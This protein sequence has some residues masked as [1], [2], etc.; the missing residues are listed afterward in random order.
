MGFFKSLISSSDA[1]ADSII[2][3]GLAAMIGLMVFQGY[4]V[5]VLQHPFSPISFA[6]GAAAIMAGIGGGK[7]ARDRL[8][9]G[10]SSQPDQGK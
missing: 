3:A 4:D 5:I 10:S 7:A 1:S 2:V 6:G 9:D 8:F